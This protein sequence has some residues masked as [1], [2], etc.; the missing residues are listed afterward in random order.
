[1]KLEEIIEKTTQIKDRCDNCNKVNYMSRIKI[2]KILFNEILEMEYFCPI[3][4][5]TKIYSF[6]SKTAKEKKGEN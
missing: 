2:H 4:G 1:M 5:Y 6:D 3:C